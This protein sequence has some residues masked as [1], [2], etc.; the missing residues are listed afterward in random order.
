MKALLVMPSLDNGYWK[1]LGKKVGPKSEPLSLLYIATFLND[2]GHKAEILDCEA[3]GISYEDLEQIIKNNNY[4]VVAVAMLTSMFSQ[5]LEVC[6]IAKKVNPKIKTVVG[7]SHASVRP[8]ETAQE[9]VIDIVVIGEAEVTFKELLDAF[10]QN[11]PLTNVKGICYKENGIVIKN[12]PKPKIQDLDFFPMPDR[13]LIKMNLYRPSV[14]YYKRLPA[15]TMITTRG[16][17]YRC[18]FCATAN[19]GYR[20]HST[21]RVVQEMKMLVEEY[22]AKEILIRD[23]TFTLSRKRTI[24][25]CDAIIKEG[26]NKKVIWDCI[27]RAGLVDL[28]LLKKMKQA[29]CCGIHFGVEGGTQKLIDTIHKDATL[30][31]IRNAFKWAREAGLETRGYFMVGLPGAQ[32]EDD[33]ATINFAKEL[34]PDWAQFTVTIPYPGTQLYK[35]AKEFGTLTSSEADWDNYQTWGGFS[36]DQLPWTTHGRTSE[37]LKA[38]QRLALKSFYFRPKVIFRKM[39]NIDNWPILR[40]YVLGAAALL[41]G[42]SGRQPE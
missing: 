39:K 25:L 22:G 13:K 20:M 2:N 30:D 32:K 36:D 14:S 21:Q 3:E 5:S 41:A 6:K 23:D 7:G 19:T 10:E 34:D 40:K 38:M 29:G 8:M 1:K 4:D 11:I 15:Y 24:E 35:E 18:T 27:T 26:L 42:G 9:Q 17:P 12:E 33:M 31:Q 28:E 37:E 16:C